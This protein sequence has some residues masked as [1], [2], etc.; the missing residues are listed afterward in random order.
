MLNERNFV[1]LHFR[2]PGTDL[3]VGLL[4]GSRWLAARFETLDGTAHRPNL[5][6]LLTAERICPQQREPARARVRYSAVP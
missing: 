5:P 2:G 6:S 4:P 3:R 1:A